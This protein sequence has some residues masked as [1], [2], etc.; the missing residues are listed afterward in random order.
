M[1]LTG[2]PALS[3]ALTELIA[4]AQARATEDAAEG[5]GQM[6]EDAIKAGYPVTRA[7]TPDLAQSTQAERVR[8]GYTPNDP[9][10]REG[11]GVGA[12]AH[13]TERDAVT[14]SVERDGT[15]LTVLVGIPE[16]D[17]T[18]PGAIANE[19]GTLTIP[20]RPI[21]KPT[22]QDHEAEIVAAL[23]TLVEAAIEGTAL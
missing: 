5:V 16:G 21:F 23:G 13:P 8:L 6:V 22:V 12:N 18:A 15:D 17:P 4:L 19:F 14:H 10:L 7:G 1:S 9:R 11:V 3:L 2:L 20:A